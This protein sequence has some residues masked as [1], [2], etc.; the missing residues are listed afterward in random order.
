MRRHFPNVRVVRE[1]CK[2]RELDG[3]VVISFRR[4]V[5]TVA[6]YGSTKRQCAELAKLVDFITE[7]IELGAVPLES[8]DT[9][10]GD[11]LAFIEQGSET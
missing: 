4:G 10:G 6:S 11:G 3:A 8:L 9:G 2:A 5:F 1:L 7:Q